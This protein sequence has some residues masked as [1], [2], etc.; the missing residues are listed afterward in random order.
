[1]NLYGPNPAIPINHGHSR[2]FE[3]KK[4]HITSKKC[5]PTTHR[6]PQFEKEVKRKPCNIL[7]KKIESNV[8]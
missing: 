3:K 7:G 1:M 6:N 2:W 5:V 4:R 8:Q